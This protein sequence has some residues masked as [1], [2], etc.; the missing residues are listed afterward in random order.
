MLMQLCPNEQHLN[1]Q[2]GYKN[3]QVVNYSKVFKVQTHSND[4]EKIL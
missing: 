1:M 4:P 2:G 3:E